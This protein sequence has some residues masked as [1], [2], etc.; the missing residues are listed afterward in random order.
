[1]FRE[2]PERR[3][4]RDLGRVRFT[5]AS[6]ENRFCWTAQS[7]VTS[8]QV[9]RSTRADFTVDCVTATVTDVC[10]VDPFVPPFGQGYFYL[11]RA[12]APHVGS[13]GCVR[14]DGDR[15]SVCSMMP[16]GLVVGGG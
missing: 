15:R 1:M 16:S 13:W 9:A 7:G 12:L 6:N 4:R 14:T 2:T 11:V 8:Y 10:L 3:D 5:D